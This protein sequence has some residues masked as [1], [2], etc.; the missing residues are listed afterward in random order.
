MH[1]LR[2]IKVHIKTYLIFLP[3]YNKSIDL[4]TYW[5]AALSVSRVTR[6]FVG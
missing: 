3:E 6:L 5:K 4:C 2:L 1:A